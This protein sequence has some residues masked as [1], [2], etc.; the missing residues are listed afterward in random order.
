MI[1]AIIHVQILLILTL[2]LGNTCL[3]LFT[4][5]IKSTIKTYTINLIRTNT[6]QQQQQQIQSLP[7]LVGTINKQ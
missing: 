7:R 3:M 5:H 6:L 4:H 2:K 1:Q